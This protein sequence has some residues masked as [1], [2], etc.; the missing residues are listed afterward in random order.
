MSVLWKN[1]LLFTASMKNEGERKTGRPQRSEKTPDWGRLS[2]NCARAREREA[3]VSD[4][5]PVWH[6]KK[7]TSTVFLFKDTLCG[8]TTRNKWRTF[9]VVF[10]FVFL[11]SR[12]RMCVNQMCTFVHLTL[13]HK[14][15]KWENCVCIHMQWEGVKNTQAKVGFYYPTLFWNARK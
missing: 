1:S 10:F 9:V 6:Y 3:L 4:R 12:A 7:Q 15:G 11:E 5:C 13:S 8:A 2:H 14:N